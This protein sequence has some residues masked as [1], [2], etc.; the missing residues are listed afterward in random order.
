MNLSDDDLIA[1]MLHPD[2]AIGVKAR[3]IFDQRHADEVGPKE[4]PHCSE[5][6]EGCAKCQPDG[7]ARLRPV[8]AVVEDPLRDLWGPP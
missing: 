3:A 5:C 8:P 2:R 7:S 4:P 1:A 6:F